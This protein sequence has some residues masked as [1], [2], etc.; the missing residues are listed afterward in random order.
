MAPTYE[1]LAESFVEEEGVLIAQL[2]FT[3][4]PVKFEGGEV[5][6]Y[7]KVYFFSGGGDGKLAVGE[8]FTGV[9]ECLDCMQ[10]YV[11]KKTDLYPAENED[12]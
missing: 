12:L 2:D 3:A 11:T 7:P 1:E 5:E 6:G 10:E 9:T 4:H 8:L